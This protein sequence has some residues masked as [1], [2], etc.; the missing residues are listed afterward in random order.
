MDA[1]QQLEPVQVLEDGSIILSAEALASLGLEECLDVDVY[2]DSVH[3]YH[4]PSVNGNN[5]ANRPN[6]EFDDERSDPEILPSTTDTDST[7]AIHKGTRW[8]R[9]HPEKWKRNTEMWKE[10]K[11]TKADVCRECFH[12]IHNVVYLG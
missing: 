4:C 5:A 9:P 7:R 6:E 8:R 11:K 3:I 1:L 12:C 10:S 2:S